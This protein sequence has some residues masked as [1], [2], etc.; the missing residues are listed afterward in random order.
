MDTIRFQINKD[1]TGLTWEEYETI[2]LAQEGDVK[3]R[4]L[5]P[6]VARFMVDE[7]GQP[8][9]HK[10]AVDILGRLPLDEIKDVFAKFTEAMT[11]SAV[12]LASGTT[13]T[14]PSL[15]NSA[16]ASQTG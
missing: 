4:R 15:A 13:S 10:D 2:E 1:K 12:P 5:R 6:L 8:L 14:S 11:T 3:M 7:Q 9:P 16:E